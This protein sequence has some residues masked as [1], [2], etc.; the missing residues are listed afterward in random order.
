MTRL[1]Y[2]FLKKKD[3]SITQVRI[4]N[5]GIFKSVMFY[6]RKSI[7][8]SKMKYFFNCLFIKYDQIVIADINKEIS[9][10]KPHFWCGAEAY[11]QPYQTTIIELFSKIVNS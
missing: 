10:G 5:F 7:T 11:L 1:I 9:K 8:T 3:E 4:D 6:L 2:T